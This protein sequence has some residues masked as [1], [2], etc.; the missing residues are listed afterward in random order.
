M[1][2]RAQA[3]GYAIQSK[4]AVARGQTVVAHHGIQ[5]SGSNYLLMCLRSLRVPVINSIDPDRSKPSHKHFRWQADKSTI[6]EQIRDEYGNDLVASS[7]SEIEAFARYPAR[8]RHIV[9]RKDEAGWL[10]SI[11]NWGLSCQW[12]A[13]KSEAMQAAPELL[14]DFRAY[15]GVW[16]SLA[17]ENPD[18]VR[19][20]RFEDV[21]AQ[22]RLLAETLE[23]LD[24]PFD[25]QNFS[26]R[27]DEVPRSPKTRQ[28]IV[29][30]ADIAGLGL[31][32][33][34]ASAQAR[35]TR[36]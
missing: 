26:G 21:I 36:H 29:S 6:L 14:A 16:Q 9:I 10:K 34:D 18:T 33:S 19:V 1:K 32:A 24:V 4:R 22:P 20:L 27:F 31:A 13:D 15:Y 2:D 28:Q 5:R 11:M 25:A 17:D 12:F 3:L 30:A 8:C 35:G 23:A 7:L